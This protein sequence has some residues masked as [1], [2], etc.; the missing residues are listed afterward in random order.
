M[1][2]PTLSPLRDRSVHHV[3]VLWQG[4]ATA[5]QKA[6]FA[7]STP[8]YAASGLL[9]YGATKGVALL[10]LNGLLLTTNY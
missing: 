3:Q 9:T 6:E 10:S 8:L 5:M 1:W 4:Y 2:L 7:A